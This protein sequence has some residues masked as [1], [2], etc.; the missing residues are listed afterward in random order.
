MNFHAQHS[1]IVGS[2]SLEVQ[3]LDGNYT[4]APLS[5]AQTNSRAVPKLLFR[6]PSAVYIMYSPSP[7]TTTKRPCIGNN[8]SI[9]NA[10][11]KRTIGI[12]LE[13]LRIDFAAAQLLWGKSKPLSIDNRRAYTGET[14]ETRKG[15]ERSRRNLKKI[16]KA[17][18]LTV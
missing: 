5:V 7:Q 9:G 17:F 13:V 18:T 3:D 12:V 4:Y 2:S 14:L 15:G 11:S 6:R 16:P 10:R 8:I 1:W